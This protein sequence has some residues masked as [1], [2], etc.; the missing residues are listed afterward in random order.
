MRLIDTCGWLEYFTDGPL[1][2]NYG[3]FLKSGGKQLLVPTLVV[4]EVYKFLSR[5]AG[6]EVAILAV[7]KLKTC[8]VVDLDISLAMEAADFS[9]LHRLAMADA[10]VYATARR[11]R[12]EL[13]TSDA[14]FKTLPGVRF[15]PKTA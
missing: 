11:F 4:Y 1:A 13:V 9:L 5:A 3:R 8:E 10:V 14:D 7:S 2:R 12:A 6:E 15:I